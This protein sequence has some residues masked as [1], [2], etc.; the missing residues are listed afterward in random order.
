MYKAAYGD[1]RVPTR[2]V[3]PSMPPWPEAAWGMKLGSKVSQIRG[4][5]KYIDNNL[6]RREKLDKLGFV[7]R[8]R[9]E[10]K[11]AKDNSE[12]SFD[13]IYD[14]LVVYKKEFNVGGELTVPLQFTVPETDPWPDN[15]KG[16]PLGRC[17]SKLRTKSFLKQ[18]PEAEEKLKTIGFQFDTKVAANDIR[19]QNVYKALTR[20]KEVYGDLLVPQPFEVPE[21]SS[22]WPEETWGLRL[23]ARV[24]AIRSQGTFVKAN[25]DRRQMLDDIGFVWSPPESERRKRGRKSNAEKEREEKEK[26]EA[27]AARQVNAEFKG[28]E[29]GDEVDS[30]ISSFDFS[31]MSSDSKGEESISP[32]WGL[33]GGRELKDIVTAAQEEAAQQ[34]VQD[35]YKP[36]KTLAESLSEARDRA[37]A[38]NI[39][40]EGEGKMMRKG[41]QEKQ[42]PWFNDDFGGEFV[43]DDVV[44]ALTLYKSLYG[45]FSNLTNEEFIIPIRGEETISFD[46]EN[47]DDFGML[48]DASTRAATAI[49][50][51]EEIDDLAMTEDMLEAEISRL[52]EEVLSPEMELEMALATAVPAVEA[53]W[54]EHLEGMRLGNIVTRI[55]D[56]SLEVKHLPE[57][58]A[59]LDAIDFDWGDPK[60]FLDIPFEKAMCAMYGYYLVRGD[61]FV[62]PEFVM[63]DEDPWPQALAGYEVGQAVKRIRELQNSFEAYHP[64]KVS[65]LR[66]IDFVWFPTLALPLDPEE[67]EMSP[68][69]IKLGAL[70]HPDYARLHEIPMGLPD[71]IV[72][73]GPFFDSD[74]PKQWWRKWHSWDHVADVWYQLGRRD[75]AYVLRGLGYPAMA[76]EHEEKYGKGLFTQIEETREILNGDIRVESTELREELLEKLKFYR[77]EL[78]GCSDLPADTLEELIEEMDMKMLELVTGKNGE[79]EEDLIKAAMEYEEEEVEEEY[80]YEYEEVETEGEMDEEAEYEEVEYEEDEFDFEEELGLDSTEEDSGEEEKK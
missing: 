37:I 40:K 18:N 73:D 41:K 60:Y 53:S 44:E 13:Q 65:L 54:P 58:K 3:V 32:T 51:F 12:I 29:D 46:D 6:K 26:L 14:A 57:R 42:I 16:L 55:R 31:A 4:E 1:L 49:A 61:M 11:A 35:D 72:A 59:Q 64:E 66:M 8:L 45:N 38:V 79:S 9:A 67:G 69:F 36:P 75:N 71:K 19:F 33:E 25:E 24:N 50:R 22:E 70:G 68:E 23:G 39:I 20:Y 77:T 48:E 56:G 74:D 47:E 62:P 27:A 10:T 28:L 2:F 17:I 34:A 76:A 43:F 80:E 52:Q 30:F 78:E 63:P 7:W 15:T 5:G 21:E